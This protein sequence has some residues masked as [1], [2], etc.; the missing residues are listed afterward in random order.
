MPNI[1]GLQAKLIKERFFSA[2]EKK[3]YATFD[4]SAKYN[5]NIISTRNGSHDATKFDD[6][7]VV[8]Y[9]DDD[10][11]WVVNSYEL[12]TDPGPNILRRPLNAKGT[13]ILVP[14]QYRGTY[15]ID[16]H[17]GKT[18]YVAL[19]QRLGKVKVYRDDDKD[20]KLEMDPSTIDE[21]MFG[22]NIHRHA[23]ADEREY[24]RGASAGCQVFK[25]NADFREFMAL[26]N[27]SAELFT[28]SFTYTLL[29]EKD[30]D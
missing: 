22:I 14:G 10:K 5:L 16:V 21:G 19:C 11:E 7:M 6:L 12:T 4:G 23:G 27:K 29:D 3:G 24:V 8:I 9:R 30:L 2:M 15:K 26:C 13:A 17:G 25:N 18:K 28:N 20:T 1:K